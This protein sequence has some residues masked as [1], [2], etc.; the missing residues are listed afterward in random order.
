MR[1]KTFSPSDV[2]GKKVLVQ[3]GLQRPP[4]RRQGRRRHA[5]KGAPSDADGSARR[6]R[7]NRARLAPRPPEGNGQPQ[8]HARARRRRAREADRMARALRLRLHR[9]EGRRSR[10]GLERRRS[11]LLENVRFHPEEEKNDMEFAK[12]LVKNFDVFVMDAFSAAHRAHAST[13]AAAE[14]IPSFSGKL[15]DR[16]ITMLSAAA[17]RAEEALRAHPR[18]S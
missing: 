6:G 18:R 3:G 10:R 17:R 16:E 13:R 5:H 2:A 12:K 8:I 11:A 1:L 4:G 14:L 15:I 9:R 7:K